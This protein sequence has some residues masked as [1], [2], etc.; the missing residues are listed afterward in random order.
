[1]AQRAALD[2]QQANFAKQLE[3]LSDRD[4]LVIE[5]LQ[6]PRRGQLESS[7]LAPVGSRF[8]H[9]K[10]NKGGEKQKIMTLFEQVF[11]E[12]D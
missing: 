11:V 9:A 8:T 2:D 7:A 3:A 12:K 10:P 1:M 6:Q 4:R 5:Q